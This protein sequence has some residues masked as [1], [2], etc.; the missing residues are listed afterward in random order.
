MGKVAIDETILSSIADSIRGDTSAL[1]YYPNEMPSAVTDAINTS[2]NKGFLD[3]IEEGKKSQYDEFWDLVTHNGNRN[4][5]IYAFNRWGME[6]IQPPYKIIAID[7]LSGSNTFSENKQLKKVEAQYFDFSQKQRGTTNTSGWYYTFVACHALEEIEDIG[8]C[9]QYGYIGTFQ[10]CLSLHTIARLGFDENT[11]IDK[12]FHN[13][14]EL[15][16]LTVEG[17]IGKN[18][19]NLQWSTKLS[20]ASWQSI[21]NALSTTATGLSI[22]GSLVSVNKAFET[23]EGANDGVNSAKWLNL[24]ST[25]SNWTINLV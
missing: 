3:G 17:T 6:Y 23:S 7:A 8:L 12:A 9:P 21:I 18:G 15:Q 1:M 10:S 2:K 19:L 5:F 20:K 11:L 14:N 13:C 22:T 24:L 4:C 16:N 25:K